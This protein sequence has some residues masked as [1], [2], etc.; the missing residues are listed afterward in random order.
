MQIQIRFKIIYF[1][2][3]TPQT[4]L[5]KGSGSFDRK[6]YDWKHIGFCIDT[7]HAFAAGY[8]LRKVAHINNFIS[9]VEKNLGWD[10][11]ELIHLNDSKK[12][13]GCHVD[14]HAPLLEGYIYGEQNE[15]DIEGL[16]YLVNYLNS[17]GKSIVLETKGDYKEELV[18]LNKLKE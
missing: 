18:L 7:C 12:H 10:N 1:S 15:G 11:V 8:D 5:K 13:L 17:K 9:K 4:A 6:K 3:T 2:F 16:K 14:R